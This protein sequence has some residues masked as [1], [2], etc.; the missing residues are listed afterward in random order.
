MGSRTVGRV[1]VLVGGATARS[2]FEEYL[3]CLNFRFASLP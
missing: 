3:G 1:F 2:A